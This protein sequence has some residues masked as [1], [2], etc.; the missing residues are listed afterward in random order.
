MLQMFEHYVLYRCTCVHACSC[1]HTLAGT[2]ICMVCMHVC[3]CMYVY[4]CVCICV[5]VCLDPTNHWIIQGNPEWLASSF[6]R[7]ET[8]QKTWRGLVTD[9]VVLCMYVCV[10][11]CTAQCMYCRAHAMF[12]TTY[13]C[14]CVHVHSTVYV[15]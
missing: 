4:M 3:V 15:L 10:Y 5:Y 11:M 2:Y 8:P 6:V 12:L 13:V 7:T 1:L 9:L 14:M